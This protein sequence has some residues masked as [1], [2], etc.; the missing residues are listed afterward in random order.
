[1]KTQPR[2][3]PTLRRRIE[4]I[5]EFGV[6]RPGERVQDVDCPSHVQRL[7]QPTRGR[8]PRVD[9]ESLRLVPRPDGLDGI[10]G[11]RRG[12]R[13]L[14]QEPP[15]RAAEPKLAVRLSIKPVALLGD[16]TVVPA[17]EHSEIRERSGAP[18]CP[19]ADVMSLAEP[20]AATRKTAAAVAVMERSP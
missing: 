6:R 16:R 4:G 20:N 13:H 17:T 15:V 3:S 19:V 18:L 2:A 8:G 5:R 1:M 12:W 11:R 9:A 10:G 7:S 14:G